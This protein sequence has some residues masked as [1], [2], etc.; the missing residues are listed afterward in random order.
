[1]LYSFEDIE[2][3]ERMLSC[4]LGADVIG[5]S[6]DTDG[7]QYFIQMHLDDGTSV[8]KAYWPQSNYMTWGIYP[9]DGM[10]EYVNLLMTED[11]VLEEKKD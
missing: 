6:G 9:D 5:I 8:T 1:M 3:L 11:S 2:V 4:I 10:P 7:P